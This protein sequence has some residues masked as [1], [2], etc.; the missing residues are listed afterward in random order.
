MT[1]ECENPSLDSEANQ[2]QTMSGHTLHYKRYGQNSLHYSVYCIN[3]TKIASITKL[4]VNYMSYEIDIENL[5]NLPEPDAHCLFDNSDC[6][7]VINDIRSI[8]RFIGRFNT[9]SNRLLDK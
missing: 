1:N 6:Q 2:S 9:R 4:D 5:I 8:N 3:C 7:F